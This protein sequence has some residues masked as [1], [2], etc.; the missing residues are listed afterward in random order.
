MKKVLF[1]LTMLLSFEL[2]TAQTYPTNP[3]NGKVEF[4][5]IIE[6]PGTQSQLF[7]K[8]ILWI[9][10]SFKQATKVI[11]NEDKSAGVIICKGNFDYRVRYIVVTGKGRKE[12]EEYVTAPGNAEFTL[13]IFV[14]DGKCKLII[15]DLM[16]PIDEYLTAQIGSNRKVLFDAVAL[17]LDTTLNRDTEM[18]TSA[19]RKNREE[20]KQVIADECETVFENITRYLHRK[21][22][23]D[24]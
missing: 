19:F 17:R 16:I 1:T 14:K 7:D 21:A 22:E 23:N 2:L 5:K 4:E 3:D 6:V 20:R 24:F 15:T 9:H 18:Q 10:N 11:E 13:K 12:K 8:S